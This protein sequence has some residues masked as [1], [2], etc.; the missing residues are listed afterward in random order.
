MKF[1]CFLKSFPY[2]FIFRDIIQYNSTIAACL[3]SGSRCLGNSDEKIASEKEQG[4]QP[5]PISN[6]L[7]QSELAHTILNSDHLGSEIIK[8]EADGRLG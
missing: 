1:G 5:G 4:I 7:T 6:L 8:V 2:L 3:S